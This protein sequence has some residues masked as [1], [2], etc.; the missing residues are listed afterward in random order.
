MENVGQLDSE[1][2]QK[3]CFQLMFLS[4]IEEEFK[5]LKHANDRLK[6]KNKKFMEQKEK[7]EAQL[8]KLK[9]ENK[10]WIMESSNLGEKIKIL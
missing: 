1:E 4:E 3:A 10:K 2:R 7:L 9:Q 8:E 6:S 5:Q